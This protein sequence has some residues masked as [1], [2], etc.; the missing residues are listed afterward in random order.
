[1][2]K[3][4]NTDGFFSHNSVVPHMCFATRKKAKLSVKKEMHMKILPHQK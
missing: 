4:T 3:G 2:E 1:M